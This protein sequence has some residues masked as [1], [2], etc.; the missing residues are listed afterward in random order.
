MNGS[1]L[2]AGVF[3]VPLVVAVVNVAVQVVAS[4]VRPTFGIYVTQLVGIACALPVF[5]LLTWAFWDAPGAGGRALANA[6]IYVCFCYVYFH[7]NN[8]GETARRVR[9]LREMAIAAR[10]LS[11]AEILER[12][13]A[14]EV[15]G[16]RLVRLLD[17][18]QVVQSGD[19]L[20]I[21][22]RSVSAMVSAVNLVHRI[23]FGVRRS[24]P[25][26]GK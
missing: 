2:S 4:R 20:F 16:R 6:G 5:G 14:S 23:V 18:G 7:F 12:Y 13:G 17:A 3:L 1:W 21:A 8:M 10:P 11:L 26:E 9:L 24:N 19:R 15:L 25:L 22:N